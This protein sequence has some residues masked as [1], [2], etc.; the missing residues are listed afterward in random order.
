MSEVECQRA[1]GRAAYSRATWAPRR[2]LLLTRA[3]LA[4]RLRPPV[5]FKLKTRLVKQARHWSPNHVRQALERLV[6]AEADCK[7][8]NM[9]D[10]TLCARVLF[11]LASLGARR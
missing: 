7:R 4:V 1:E 5:F 6:D 9:P 3:M 11:Q 8:T 10:E 2:A